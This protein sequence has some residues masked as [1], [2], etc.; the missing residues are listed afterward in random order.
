MYFA[1]FASI[2]KIPIQQ[3]IAL[4]K[5]EIGAFLGSLIGYFVVVIFLAFMGL[6]MWVL[7]S[8]TNVLDAGYANI[9][10]LFTI[11]PYLYL[12]LIPAITMRSFAEE[13]RS[14]TLELLLTS[15][16]TELQMILAKYYAGCVLVLFSLIPT[17]VYYFTVYKYGNPAGNIDTGGMWGSY[18][19]LALLG[20][21]F[22][23]IGVFTSSVTDNQVIAFVIGVLLCYLCYLGFDNLAEIKSF[24]SF[25]FLF[26]N[27]SINTHY[28]SMSR[29]VIDTRDVLY[30][31]GLI[32]IFIFSTKAVIESRKW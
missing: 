21:A 4:L 30:F 26:L 14:G 32:S 1:M 25:D 2:I 9:D 6:F 10:G 7:P 24:K 23:A 28:V 17:L 18:I 19:G 31:L 20:A 5:K 12:F 15:P 22:V 8:E 16:I 11:T 29:G 13:K 27:L 3:M